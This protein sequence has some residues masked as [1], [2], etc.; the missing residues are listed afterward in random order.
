MFQ[1][2]EKGAPG[3]RLQGSEPQSVGVNKAVQEEGLRDS[4]Y[5]EESQKA[6]ASPYVDGPRKA[7]YRKPLTYA[8]AV[9][10]SV[11]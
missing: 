1:L 9:N 10:N 8:E 11:W 4:S 2:W 6:M 3:Q 5:V 7:T